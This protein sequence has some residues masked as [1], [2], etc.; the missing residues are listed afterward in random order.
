M[1]RQNK[2]NPDRYKTGG[3]LSPDDLARERQAQ[4][5]AIQGEPPRG[6][7]ERP[8]WMKQDDD[9]A[10]RASKAEPAAADETNDEPADEDRNSD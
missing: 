1:S 9:R 8:S 10:A 6:G 4:Q 3:R 7:D 5:T 2:V